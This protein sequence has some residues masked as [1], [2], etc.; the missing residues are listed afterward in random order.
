MSPRLRAD[1][2][3]A[4]DLSVVV[5][6][7]R[8]AVCAAA[9][10]AKAIGGGINGAVGSRAKGVGGDVTSGGGPADYLAEGVD[11]SG[12]TEVPMSSVIGPLAAV[13]KAQYGKC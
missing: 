6:T 10:R 12:R 5:D 3:R 4:D 11:A 13:R 1:G 8:P 2:S 7:I 9:E